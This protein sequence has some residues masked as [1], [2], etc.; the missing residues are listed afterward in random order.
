MIAQD[1]LRLVLLETAT[2]AAESCAYSNWDDEFAR[3]NIRGV[4]A[5]TDEGLRKPRNRKLSIA[6]L[7]EAGSAQ[8]ENLGFARWKLEDD[9]VIMLIP[10][11]AWNYVD[12]SD[13][14]DIFGKQQINDDKDLDHRMGCTAFGFLI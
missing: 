10:L 13:L 14:L 2:R 5:D 11:W 6:E 7:R 3:R 4:W 8:L 9:R 12:T 1:Y